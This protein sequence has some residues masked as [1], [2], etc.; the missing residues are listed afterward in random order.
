MRLIQELFASDVG[1]LSA[2]VIFITLAMGGYY[3]RYFLQHMHDDEQRA[4]KAR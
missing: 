1:V 4:R 3:L 2:I